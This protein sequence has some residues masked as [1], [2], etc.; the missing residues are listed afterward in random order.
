[1]GMVAWFRRMAYA[2]VVLG[3]IAYAVAEQN[4]A[5]V[6]A[7]GT[8]STLS[9]Y[10][11]EGPGGR[12]LPRWLINLGVILATG[13]L[14]FTQRPPPRQPL[15]IGL[16]QFILCIQIFKLYESKQNR[17]WAQL[18]VL[19]LMQMVCASII[20]AEIVYG[21]L[22]MAYLVVTLFT[23]LLFQ[24]K[25]GYDTVL[26]ATAAQMPPGRPPIRPGSVASRG[27]ARQ[28]YALTLVTGALCLALSA[29]I[30]VV[31]PR[32]QGMG[33]LGDWQAPTRRTVTGFDNKVEL[34]G[35]SPATSRL[36]VMNVTLLRDGV[37]IGS[38]DRTFLL[39]GS[40]LD[41]YDPRSHRWTRSRAA[42][43]ADA[44]IFLE[45]ENT[46]LLVDPAEFVKHKAIRQVITLRAQTHNILLGIYPPLRVETDHVKVLS[47]SPQDQLLSA[48]QPISGS[49]QY[50]VE[51]AD[52]AQ[53]MTQPYLSHWGH[54]AGAALTTLDFNW[55]AYARKPVVDDPRVRRLTESIMKAQGLT[56]DRAA[57]SDPADPAIA[58]A[59][60]RYLQSNLNYS[61]DLPEM[62]ADV[63]PIGAFLFE[64]RRGHCEYFAS[65]MAA[66]LRSVGVRCRVVTGFRANEYNAV[67][68]YYVVRQKNAHAWV[69]A[70]EDSTG[71]RTYDA[72]PP[73]G[74]EEVQRLSGGLVASLRDLYEYLEFQWI[75]NVITYDDTQRASVIISFDHNLAAVTAAAKAAWE[76]VAGWVHGLRER[77]LLG[78]AGF[79]LVG[80]ILWAIVVGLALLVRIVVHRR[81]AI[82]QLQLEAVSRRDQRRMAQHLEFYLQMLQVLERA[83]HSKPLWQTPAHFAASLVGRDL[84]RFE[85][86]V[87]LTDLFYEIRF[88][89]RPLD[90]PRARRIAGELE[91]L[92]QSIRA[93]AS[94]SR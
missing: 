43:R 58:Q 23:V 32:G 76:F 83:G 46:S 45:H 74:L 92:R 13:W 51:S 68:G 36:P 31:M 49:I 66:M 27:H 61:L 75:N 60:E 21:I 87:S 22:L 19:S 34:G 17:D 78:P 39:R 73:A 7:A 55:T 5:M 88:G 64:Y 56:R 86:V 1:M 16:G 50:V 77:W 72:S 38:R 11:V 8:L 3:V 15:I 63:E 89:G 52:P 12:P 9:W 82:R 6:L 48:R 54:A 33:M 69:E 84:R 65:G 57:E 20:S 94:A 81:R 93:T 62:A 29:A 37:N 2:Q 41:D 35:A 80:L 26:D 40:P 59:V 91:Q 30:F 18:I 42:A 24:L 10:V 79:V 71:W 70:W 90:A 28:F 67:G 53:D 47:F 85:P 44:D 14:F 4:P 25:Q